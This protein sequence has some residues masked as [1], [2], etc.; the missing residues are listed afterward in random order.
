MFLDSDT[1]YPTSNSRVTKEK[2]E[3]IGFDETYL[4]SNC[5]F[6]GIKEF[7]DVFSDEQYTQLC[8]NVFH[9]DDG[10]WS[11]RDFSNIRGDEKFSES[12]KR[13]LSRECRRSIGKPEISLELSRS[14]SCEEIR[15]FYSSYFFTG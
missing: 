11:N 14:L 1:Q 5:F 9:K 8:N 3:T 10:V 7:E 4:G 2:L 13:L 15:R 6:I 12:L